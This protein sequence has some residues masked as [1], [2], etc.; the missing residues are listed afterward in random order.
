MPPPRACGM[1]TNERLV[2]LDRAAARP[3]A[4]ATCT[5]MCAMAVADLR[6]YIEESRAVAVSLCSCSCC[7]GVLHPPPPDVAAAMDDVEAKITSHDVVTFVK[8]GCR[9]CSAAESRLRAMQQG[10]G[11][12]G[13]PGFSLCT[14]P[15]TEIA[16]RTALGLELGVAVNPRF[17][18]RTP[19]QIRFGVA[20]A[21]SVASRP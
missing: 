15:G 6:G 10:S 18:T 4:A 21:C 17:L 19:P 16:V 3:G 2:G 1:A 8:D 7:C 14:A 9:F 11:N 20:L 5:D 12:G 13:R